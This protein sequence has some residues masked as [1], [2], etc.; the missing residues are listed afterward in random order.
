KEK[1]LNHEGFFNK[2]AVGNK[3]DSVQGYHLS[4]T[5]VTP[6]DQA[7]YPSRPQRERTSHSPPEGCPDLCGISTRKVYPRYA[8]LHTAGSFYLPF[9]PLPQQVGAVI[10]CGTICS[11]FHKTRL[12]TGAMLYVV[13]TFLVDCSTR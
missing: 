2:I 1:A 13:R 12:F 4:V 9:S 5:K 11:C 10:F 3:P 6:C 7:A 8:L